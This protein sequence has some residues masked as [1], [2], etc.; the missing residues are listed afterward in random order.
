MPTQSTQMLFQEALATLFGTLSTGRTIQQCKVP[1]GTNATHPGIF[2]NPLPE[3]I[4][5]ATNKDDDYIWGVNVILTSASNRDVRTG[6]TGQTL[7]AL[8][9]DRQRMIRLCHKQIV[10]ASPQLWGVVEPGVVI[11]PT[12]FGLNYDVSTFVV[13]GR[14]RYTR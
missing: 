6:V 13:R 4:A 1:W 3:Q 10:L 11:D 9:Y 14:E 5:D 12:A 2:L 8:C 7:D